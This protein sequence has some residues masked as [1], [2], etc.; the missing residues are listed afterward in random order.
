MSRYDPTDNVRGE[1]SPDEKIIQEAK[2]RFKKV[3]DW[4]ADFRRLYLMDVKF[5]NGDSDNGW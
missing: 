2:D 1:M 3:Q 4:E 5:A